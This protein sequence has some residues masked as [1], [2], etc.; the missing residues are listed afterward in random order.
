MKINY[1]KREVT[2]QRTYHTKKQQSSQHRTKLRES[3]IQTAK[4][5][6]RCAILIDA[7]MDKHKTTEYLRLAYILDIEDIINKND[8][9]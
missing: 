5:R 1:Q 6:K 9:I 4:H 3:N 8:F 7:L 2:R